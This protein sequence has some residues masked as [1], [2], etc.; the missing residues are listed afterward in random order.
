MSKQYNQPKHLFWLTVNLPEI[1]VKC[2]RKMLQLFHGEN[3]L[4]CRK[5]FISGWK[6]HVFI[7]SFFL[8]PKTS[9]NYLENTPVQPNFCIIAYIV[10]NHININIIPTEKQALYILFTPT[11]ENCCHSSQGL[12][13]STCY[14]SYYHFETERSNLVK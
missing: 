11:V 9:F 2:Q 12:W 3:K 7:M 1:I 10:I 14:F 6:T 8:Y 4:H 5:V 13:I